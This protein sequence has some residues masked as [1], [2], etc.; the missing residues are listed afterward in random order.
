M[1][2][3]SGKALTLSTENGRWNEI[4]RKALRK[5]QS[6]GGRIAC[7]ELVSESLMRVKKKSKIVCKQI[8]MN[9]QPTGAYGTRK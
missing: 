4:L 3:Q 2:N 5:T 1:L 7:N 8:N 6:D 9:S